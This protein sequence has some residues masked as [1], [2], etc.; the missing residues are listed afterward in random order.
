[1]VFCNCIIRW[2][3]SANETVKDAIAKLDIKPMSVEELQH[4]VDEIIAKCNDLKNSDESV[5]TIMGNVMKIARNRID[6]KIVKDA[7][8]TKLGT[9]G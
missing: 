2:L 3:K 8:K 1:M 5:K 9:F 4:V 7:V 6:G